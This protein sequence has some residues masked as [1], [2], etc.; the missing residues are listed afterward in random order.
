MALAGAHVDQATPRA[1]GQPHFA[2]NA[3]LAF[4]ALTAKDT[5]ML[6]Y[7]ARALMASM[8]LAIAFVPLA[9]GEKPAKTTALGKATAHH[10]AR[11]PMVLV[12]PES[13]H[14]RMDGMAAGARICAP[15]MEC[16]VVTGRATPLEA[17][18]AV[19]DGVAMHAISLAQGFLKA[20]RRAM[21]MGIVL[22]WGNAIVT[23]RSTGQAARMHARL[24]MGWCVPAKDSA[25]KGH[26]AMALALAGQDTSATTAPA[27]ALVAQPMLALERGGATTEATAPE[28]A[29]AFRGGS[30]VHAIRC[31]LVVATA[32]AMACVTVAAQALECAPASEARAECGT[33]AIAQIALLGS[34]A[35]DVRTSA[36][37]V[38]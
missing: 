11:A 36:L 37:T 38:W 13:A 5:V 15:A 21:A 3:R 32:L 16:A 30:E 20:N 6:A 23:I 29:H 10:T 35:V 7:E 34:G 28:S 12:G 27:S 9:H 24:L 22:H 8:A 1:T 4:G 2:S 18:C 33:E 25:T 19:Q 26:K 31:V 17:V 14:A